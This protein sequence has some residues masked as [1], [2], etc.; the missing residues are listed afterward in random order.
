MVIVVFVC[1]AAQH[2][3]WGGMGMVAR[4][5]SVRMGRFVCPLTIFAEKWS[6]LGFTFR[7][8]GKL[9]NITMSIDAGFA[10]SAF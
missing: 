3:L 1:D 10:N 6:F 4:R 2:I 7:S 5:E 9:D 8:C